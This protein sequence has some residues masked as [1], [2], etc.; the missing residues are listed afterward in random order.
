MSVLERKPFHGYYKVWFSNGKESTAK[1]V[2]HTDRFPLSTS[3]SDYS[4]LFPMSEYPKMLRVIRSTVYDSFKEAFY[5][6]SKWQDACLPKEQ[7]FYTY[8]ASGEILGLSHPE[9][10]A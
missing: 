1:L 10:T 2:V 9:K 6:R 5:E 4:R 3:V 8:G 7:Q